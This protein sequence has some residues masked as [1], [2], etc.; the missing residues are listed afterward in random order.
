MPNII[1][2]QRHM[3]MVSFEVGECGRCRL[4]LIETS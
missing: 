3:K 4:P 2:M 1:V